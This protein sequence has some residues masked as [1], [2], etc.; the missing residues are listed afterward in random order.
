MQ[1]IRVAAKAV[2]IREGRLLLVQCRDEQ[3]DWYGL[4]GGGQELG[5]TLEAAIV[6]ECREEIDAEVRVVGLRYVRD[7]IVAHH[8]FSY[9]DEAQHQVEHLF[10]CTVPDDYVPRSGPGPDRAQVSVVWM[11]RDELEGARVY[12]SK[13]RTLLDPDRAPALPV[14]WGDTN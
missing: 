14:Y 12:P 5:E 8:D 2:I 1:G 4:P 3:G 11:G 6:R 9:L 13:L 10:E 7:Y